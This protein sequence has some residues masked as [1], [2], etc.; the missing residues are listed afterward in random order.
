MRIVNLFVLDNS[1]SMSSIKQAIISGFN[2]QVESIK[3]LDASNGTQSLFGFV[4]FDTEVKIRYLNESINA[5]EP[6]TFKSYFPIG[7]TAFHDAIGVSIKALEDKLGSE[8]ETAKV[9]VTFLTDGEENSSKLYKGSQAA[10]LIKQVQDEYDWT[11]S[12]IGANI[13]VA[14]L[15]ESL[16]VDKSNTLNFVASAEGTKFATDTLKSARESYYTKSM[17]GKQT[18]TAFF[19]EDK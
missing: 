11:F 15:A 16:H 12:F 19:T 10:D 9:L 6:L 8:L 14:K 5:A 2:E 13:D 18:K 4:T 3:A 7:G 1:G 17:E